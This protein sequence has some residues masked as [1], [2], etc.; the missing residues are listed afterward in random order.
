M[1]NK[2]MAAMLLIEAAEILKNVSNDKVKALEEGAVR[3]SKN[4]KLDNYLKKYNYKGDNK[5]GTIT[6]DGEEY[7]VNRCADSSFV[8]S[9]DGK[10]L[11]DKG[12]LHIL[13]L[14]IKFLLVMNLSSLKIINVEMQ[15]YNMK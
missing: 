15:C 13:L 2:E 12:Q 11:L 3:T 1:N 7:E 4:H 6:V 10:N 9:S 8:I 14:K 5:S